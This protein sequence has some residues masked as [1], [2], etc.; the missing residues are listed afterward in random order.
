MRL[1]SSRFWIGGSAVV[2]TTLVWSSVGLLLADERTVSTTIPVFAHRWFIVDLSYHR[3]QDMMDDSS[4][5]RVYHEFRVRA[6]TENTTTDTY[7]QY[8]D[9]TIPLWPLLIGD[10]Q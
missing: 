2:L 8:A 7:I 5:T 4:A 1:R 9:V 3:L 10:D 6:G